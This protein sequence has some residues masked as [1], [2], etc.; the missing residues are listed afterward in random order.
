[1]D[2]IL[3]GLEFIMKELG[4]VLPKL[5]ASGVDLKGFKIAKGIYFND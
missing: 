5:S 4:F 3:R 1:M 2:L